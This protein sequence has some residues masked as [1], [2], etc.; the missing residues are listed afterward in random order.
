M[1][2]T[3]LYYL[4]EDIVL[5]YIH[6]G[7]NSRFVMPQSSN[8]I[9]RVLSSDVKCAHGN[10]VFF[11]GYIF[12]FLAIAE[13]WEEL[14]KTGPWLICDLVG[15]DRCSKTDI[16][17]ANRSELVSYV[18][19]SF[20][21]FWLRFINAVKATSG[22]TSLKLVNQKRAEL[23]LK[24][25]SVLP[26]NLVSNCVFKSPVKESLYSTTHLQY[27]TDHFWRTACAG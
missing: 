3:S 7:Q 8:Y 25:D 14:R 24:Y 12:C 17:A 21:C 1:P 26:S 18:T 2:A 22:T 6:F 13:I 4:R 23:F 11:C 15:F 20:N 19:D 5:G 16:N 10:S 9:R 27:V